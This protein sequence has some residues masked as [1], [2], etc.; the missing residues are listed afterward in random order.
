MKLPPSNIKN[1]L[2]LVFLYALPY[3]K[4]VA[5]NFFLLMVASFFESIGIG[6]LIPILQTI[7]QQEKTG[8]F[9]NIVKSFF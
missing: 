9:A 5:L 3:K 1:N 6:M 2:K 8:A 7:E 4:I